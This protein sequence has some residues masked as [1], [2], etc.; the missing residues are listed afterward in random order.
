MR[1]KR[2]VVVAIDRLGA[3]WLGPYGNTWLETPQ[4]N[5]LAASSL[6]CETAL[7]DAPDLA[8]IYRGY[9]T[10]QHVL[11]PDAPR[12]LP[13]LAAA[14]GVKPLLVSDDE[15]I[16]SL[17]QTADFAENR[18]V[19]AAEQS[20]AANAVAAKTI[21]ETGLFQLTTAAIET[22]TEAEG[23]ALVWIH[24]RGMDGPWDAPLEL[25]DQFAD[26]DDPLP[27]R[28]VE[29]PSR[30]L[31]EDFDP[32]ELLGL[33]QAYAGQVALADDCLGLLL[34][35]LA[36]Q[37][38]ADET[39]LIVTS[40][41]GYP[42][43]EHRRVGAG[44][45]ALYAELLQAPLLVRFPGG[46]GGLTRT[47]A[48]VQP[49]SVFATAAEALGVTLEPT[50]RELSLSRVVA[51]EPLARGGAAVAIGQEQRAIRTP[52][53]FFR[54]V[55][56]A[57]GPQRELFAKPDDRWEANEVASRC[58]EACEQLAARL[59]EFAVLARAGRLAELPPLPELLA[60]IWR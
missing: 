40:P 27:P 22:L 4:F 21:E 39:L 46:A 8:A 26:A 42:L 56:D 48:L 41:R 14:A 54:E 25:R 52:A 44:E 15:R 7:A 29:P 33:V 32:D 20:A 34:A 36:E 60:D 31:P 47:Q 24:A 17:P 38:L 37:P 19:D 50:W 35:A 49:A 3:G 59:A 57:D 28:F 23:P 12:S 53:W 10:G 5:S 11:E 18:R 13:G 43:G 1:A 9:W 55:A 6:L 16:W 30:M 45:D 2:I 51:G 58:G